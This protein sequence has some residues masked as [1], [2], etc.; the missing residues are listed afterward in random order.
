MTTIIVLSLELYSS[1]SELARRVYRGV[2]DIEVASLAAQSLQSDLKPRCAYRSAVHLIAAATKS[3][4][5][6]RGRSLD[7][8][9]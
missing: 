9:R 2:A 3:Q 7:D 4:W 8:G 1:T 6:R 5:S